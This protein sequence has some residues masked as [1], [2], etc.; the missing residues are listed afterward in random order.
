MKREKIRP[1]DVC[2]LSFHETTMM[3]VLTILILLLIYLLLGVLFV[4]PFLMKGL[5]KVDE[6]AHGGTIGFKIIIIPGVIVFW[7]VLLGRWM[8]ANKKIRE[9]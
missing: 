2:R 8:R 6:G 4:I 5:T 3:F 1:F 7:P 9:T